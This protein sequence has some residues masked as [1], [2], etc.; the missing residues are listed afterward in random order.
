[1][2]AINLTL[3]NVTSEDNGFTLTCIAENVVGMSNASVALSVYCECP[4]WQCG[5]GWQPG[6]GDLEG[7]GTEAWLIFGL[8]PQ[9]GV[10][11]VHL[12]PEG[13]Q[14]R[15]VQDAGRSQCLSFLGVVGGTWPG[16]W[17]FV[18]QFWWV[19]GL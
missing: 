14:H 13:L 18:S 12:A 9:R 19:L 4:L 17:E 16:G 8:Q 15:W 1:M 3:V 11:L 2:H 6:V 7:A 10:G 5:S